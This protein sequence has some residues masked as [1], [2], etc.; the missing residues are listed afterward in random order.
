M[1]GGGKEIGFV[2]TDIT[3]S[4]NLRRSCLNIS[5]YK[6]NVQRII[7]KNNSEELLF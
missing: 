2:T 7:H 6:K 3:G 4:A 1:L 5:A